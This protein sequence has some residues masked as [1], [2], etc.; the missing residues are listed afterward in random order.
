MVI[1]SLSRP[2]WYRPSFFLY[3]HGP[4]SP[5]LLRH[6]DVMFTGLSSSGVVTYDF[7][8]LPFGSFEYR[9][10]ACMGWAKGD[11]VKLVRPY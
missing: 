3:K 8:W 4:E 10:G 2:I 7:G 6:L 11:G 1:Y 9:L 5:L